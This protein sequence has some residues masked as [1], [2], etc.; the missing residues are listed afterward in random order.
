MN[1]LT[2]LKIRRILPVIFI[3]AGMLFLVL[4]FGILNR[5]GDLD[6]GARGVGRRL[7]SRMDRLDAKVALALEN[8]S[9]RWLDDLDLPEDMVIYRYVGDTL[10]AWANQFLI[11]NDDISTRGVVPRL[12]SPN[13]SMQS[14]LTML[15]SEPQF[16]NMGPKWY[17]A[18]M[19]EDGD[20][21][22]A[23][24]LQIIDDT[25]GG[26][27]QQGVN[28]RLR[29]RDGLS[30]EPLSVSSGREVLL[31]GQPVFKIINETM[32]A[33]APADPSMLWLALAFIIAGAFLYLFN[34]RTLRKFWI[35]SVGLLLS[36][37][38][39]HVW[40]RT[41]NGQ[42]NI[43][44]PVLFADNSF[45]WS[46][47]D[48][49]LANLTFVL[50]ISGLYIVRKDMYARIR[51][52][53]QR[54]LKNTL[55]VLATVVLLVY[56]HVS[57][58]SII[59][60]SSIS[61]ELYKLNEVS[62][63]TMV[64]YVSYI[65]MFLMVP[66]LLQMIGRWNLLTTTGNIVFSIL[67]GVYLTL[68]TSFLGY[69]KEE[70][71]MSVFANRL[72][73]ERDIETEIRL[74]MAENQIAE[75]A[76]IAALMQINGSEPTIR[77]RVMDVY[78]PW[79]AQSYGVSV[80]I[81][82][83]ADNSP[84]LTNWFNSRMKEVEPISTGSRFLYS[85]SNNGIVRYTGIFLYMMPGGGLSR[86]VLCI[87]PLT[88]RN[89]KGYFSLLENTIP[90]QVNLPERYSYAKYRG[91]ELQL[92][93]GDYAYSTKLPDD[94]HH[95]IY[96]EGAK[97]LVQNGYSHFPTRIED[98]EVVVISRPVI[99][100]NTYFVTTLF[101]ALLTFIF[102]TLV[103]HQ[104]DRK[105][106]FMKHYY[107]ARITSMLMLFLIMTLVVMA[108]V[109]ILFVFRRNNAT[110]HKMMTAQVGT[111]QSQVEY[112]LKDVTSLAELD[113][114][115]LRGVLQRIGNYTKTDITLYSTEGRVYLSTSP[116]LFESN[117][118]GHRIDGAAFHEI[119]GNNKRYYIQK[120]HIGKIVYY[121]MYAPIRNT[122]GSLM[123]ILCTPYAEPNYDF[124][125]EA[126]MHS[127]TILVVFFI[128]LIMAR[129]T[130]KEVVN[131]MFKPLIE[132]GRKMSSAN[133]DSLEYIEYDRD[134]EISALVQSYNRMVKEL[135]ESTRLLAQAERDKAWSVMARQVAHEI[136]NPLTP[137]KLQIQRVIRLKQKGD[138][139][140][141]E[142]FD[143]VS[144]VLL[145]HI[146]I[147][148][149]T[150][151]EFSIFAKLYSEEPTTFDLDKAL[152]DEILMF[153]NK[154]PVK[155]DYFGLAGAMI[156]GPKPQLT[157]VF[158]NLLNN[159]VQ[160]I[161]PES[162]GHVVVYLRNSSV[163]DGCYDIVFE[164]DGPG[165][166]EENIGKVFTP[167]FTTKSS[168]SGLGLAISRNI[169]ERC[170]AQITY[171][172]SFVLGGACFTITYP[173]L[174]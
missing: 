86:M 55:L 16:I 93:K 28:P 164:D 99:G 124:K 112:R 73:V 62:L 61:L 159:A 36:I 115:E 116:A 33:H 19:V 46:F 88:D 104:T 114:R 23:A 165:I 31:H 35:V 32:S 172:R 150:A 95:Y 102:L 134:D 156:S 168:G 162:E 163:K 98:D 85:L 13:F 151:N 138:P 171:S 54:T 127:M 173:K 89:S 82:D 105:E 148:T 118:L 141:V 52:S 149:D 81:M 18:Y 1:S 110:V 4:A 108:S 59:N 79:L 103:Q 65:L 92:F 120:D 136:K 49:L 94:L 20:C 37:C 5:T 2:K 90:G 111:L 7:S 14:L 160:A 21:R 10:Q 57:L 87:D 140:W 29:L 48:I 169:L 135:S 17:V 63:Y 125:M 83:N 157:R 100:A 80:T 139:V 155:F 109:S 84:R 66:L 40:G 154:G 51:T 122:D 113:T 145:D 133:L 128:L 47:G 24:G 43:F 131:R 78:L 11:S 123:A 27:L 126:L 77:S 60:N 30:I 25:A 121:S 129:L 75:D 53:F 8:R 144:R 50:I 64:V 68:V 158:V 3:A 137:M 147:L 143:E 67:I 39:M 174:F 96:D 167:N 34:T 42:V 130:S 41:V 97:H 45:Y 26:G 15:D 12:T 56:A 106:R 74:R 76:V 72:A 22:I 152:Q 166:S 170:N 38:A 119:V 107:R 70:D 9:S 132:M 6:A 101:L 58:C 71:R 161:G 142:R 69:R 91:N 153:D 146:D 44:S 117:V